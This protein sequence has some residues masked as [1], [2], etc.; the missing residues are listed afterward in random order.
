MR[1]TA[2]RLLILRRRTMTNTNDSDKK[3]PTILFEAI[4]R[5]AG[6]LSSA[7]EDITE[8]VVDYTQ[9]ALSSDD[10]AGYLFGELSALV[11]ATAIV[12]GRSPKEVV[13]FIAQGAPSEWPEDALEQLIQAGL[14]TVPK[15][16]E[17]DES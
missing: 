16:D 14:V 8:S 10:P 9:V 2:K 11:S 7:L 13:D 6:E 3:N 4:H 1:L 12:F 5:D 17:S 15:E